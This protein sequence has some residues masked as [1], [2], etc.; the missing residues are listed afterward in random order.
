MNLNVINTAQTN[1]SKVWARRS[2]KHG[3]CQIRKVAT[4]SVSS[5]E[6]ARKIRSEDIAYNGNLRKSQLQAVRIVCNVSYNG[7]DP[8]SPNRCRKKTGLFC[9]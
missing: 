4:A 5:V 6:R 8:S 7:G 3:D 1:I 9:Q 2:K